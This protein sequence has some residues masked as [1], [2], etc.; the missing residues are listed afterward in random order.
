M[1]KTLICVL[2][3][4]CMAAGIT[5]APAEGASDIINRNDGFELQAAAENGVSDNKNYLAAI[6]IRPEGYD[7]ASVLISGILYAPVGTEILKAEVQ[8]GGTYI[9]SGSD[10][11]RMRIN[12]NYRPAE[13]DGLPFAAD[14]ER[15]G[16]AFIFDKSAEN[17]A[18]GTAEAQ[19]KLVLSSGQEISLFTTVKT[20]RFK[21]RFYDVTRAIRDWAMYIND[22][23]EPVQRLQAR[24][25]ELGYLTP[26]AAASGKCDQATMDAANRLLAENGYQQNERFLS[27]EAMGLIE[28]GAPEQTDGRSTSTSA[29]E[30][31]GGI[32][33]SLKGTVTLFGKEIPL[34][35]LIAAG[36]ALVAL[37][38]L[39]IL[40]ITGKKRKH[41]RQQDADAGEPAENAYIT[42]PDAPGAQ[43]LTI[44]DE[45]TMDLNREEAPTGGAIFGDDEPTT[46][47]KDPGYVIKVRMI[48]EDVF[49]DKNLKLMEGGQV[50]IGRGSEAAIQTNPADTSISH[51]HGVFTASDGRIIYQ[52]ESRN[53]TRYNGQRTIYKGDTVTIPMNTKVQMEIGAHKILVIAVRG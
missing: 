27:S 21:G 5:T 50:I 45:P 19:I 35:I 51:R 20:E 38:V 26:E 3:A 29:K 30:E 14:E 23:G 25:T 18:D 15:A 44:G 24:L 53:G 10:I 11:L 40:L 33:G 1:A 52:D 7:P 34:W 13:I 2:M 43:I 41:G 22:E 6:N 36:A 48:Y 16:F 4:L 39:I 42:A 12:A 28:S 47:L 17:P 32:V 8:C 49:L 46:D 37:I 9:I 31:G